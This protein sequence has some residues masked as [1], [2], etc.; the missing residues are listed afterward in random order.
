MSQRHSGYARKERDL[1]ETPQWVTE[2][3]LDTIDIAGPIIWEPAAASGKMVEALTSRG[4]EVFASDIDGGGDDFLKSNTLPVGCRAIITNPPFNLA[5]AFIEHALR[6][7]EPVSGMVAMLLRADY[8]HA[9]TRQHLFGGCDCFALKL[10]LTRR[11]VWF[12]GGPGSPS[13]NHAWH[14]WD[15]RHR[16][17]PTLTYAP[18]TKP[19]TTATPVGVEG[20]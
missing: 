2:T 7:T 5:Q 8:D 4:F 10:A 20:I 19:E 13:T 9:R 16:G 14:L 1:Y 11:I 3:L 15:H 12:E 18:I 17:P 6:L